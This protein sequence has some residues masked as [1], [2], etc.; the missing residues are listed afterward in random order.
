MR[1]FGLP[2]TAK[3]AVLVQKLQLALKSD[4]DEEGEFGD[5]QQEQE[6]ENESLNGN[7]NLGNEAASSQLLLMQLMRQLGSKKSKLGF[8]DVDDT[9]EIFTGDK[10]ENIRL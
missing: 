9:L 7:F 5:T 2:I 6:E 3:K 10:G 4:R 8:K 1:D